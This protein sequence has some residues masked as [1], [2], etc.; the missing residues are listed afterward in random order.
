M[1]PAAIRAGDIVSYL[2]S[3]GN[4]FKSWIK[5]PNQGKQRGGIAL[6]TAVSSIKPLVEAKGLLDQIGASELEVQQAI[7]LNFFN[8]IRSKYGTFWDDRTNAFIY[9]S[10]FTG[11]IDFLR[12]HMIDYCRGK[13]SFEESTISSA[14]HLDPIGRILQEEVKGLGGTEGANKIRDRLISVFRPDQ[15]HQGFKI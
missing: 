14:L 2:G 11:A 8:A 3:S 13:G 1:D 7:F 4:P 5:L 10:G 9:A 15:I 12:T 6:S